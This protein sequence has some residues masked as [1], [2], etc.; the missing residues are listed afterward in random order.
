MQR[1]LVREKS[2][3][4]G[5]HFAKILYSFWNAAIIGVDFWV[6][7]R[8]WD[9]I[10]TFWGKIWSPVV[11]Q[12][13]WLHQRLKVFSQI[14]YRF[15]FNIFIPLGKLS[16]FSVNLG[17]RL[18]FVSPLTKRSFS[19]GGHETPLAWAGRVL[20]KTCGAHFFHYFYRLLVLKWML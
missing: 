20:S 7:L 10:P 2:K 14:S 5:R 9:N 3:Y 4:H 12:F 16:S 18:V 17:Q 6:G 19:L 13:T 15:M 8:G 1:V 11:F